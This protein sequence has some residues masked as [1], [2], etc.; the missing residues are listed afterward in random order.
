MIRDFPF[1]L[2]FPPP[3]LWVFP[4]S[5]VQWVCNP[6]SNPS[7]QLRHSL[8]DLNFAVSHF[9]FP[10]SIPVASVNTTQLLCGFILALLIHS[11]HSSKILFISLQTSV[12]FQPHSLPF[13]LLLLSSRSLSAVIRGKIPPTHY[14]LKSSLSP[15]S[16]SECLWHPRKLKMATKLPLFLPTPSHLAASLDTLLFD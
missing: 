15:S 2:S 6:G 1:L 14:N 10:V 7:S 9:F 5:G 3:L 16:L 11:M 4:H 8:D 12:S 13:P